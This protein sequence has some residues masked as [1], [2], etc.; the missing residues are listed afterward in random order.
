MNSFSDSS[1]G[2]ERTGVF[3]LIY[4]AIREINLGHGIPDIPQMVKK[5]RLQQK[6][7][8]T[9]KVRHKRY[10]IPGMHTYQLSLFWPPKGG[11]G[12][13]TMC[14][15]FYKKSVCS[16]NFRNAPIIQISSRLSPFLRFQVGR[17]GHG[18]Q[19]FSLWTFCFPVIW[20]FIRYPCM[21]IFWICCSH[22][23]RLCLTFEAKISVFK[24]G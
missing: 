21:K 17:D 5:L 19:G 12:I 14:P 3:C 6:W 24:R 7:M 9:E 8:V 2:I 11:G 13:F 4:S 23:V 22:R 1:S 18:T 15:Y 16:R 10:F 20:T